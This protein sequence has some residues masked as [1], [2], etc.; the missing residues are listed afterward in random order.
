M[1]PS[2]TPEQ[3]NRILQS[4]VNALQRGDARSAYTSARRVAANDPADTDSLIMLAQSAPE[5]GADAVQDAIHLLA[6]AIGAKPRNEDVLICWGNLKASSGDLA[7]AEQVFRMTVDQFPASPGAAQN[8]AGVLARNGKPAEAVDMFASLI[9]AGGGWPVHLGLVNACMMLGDLDR[10]ETALRTVLQAQP[11]HV[12][13]L[14][15]MGQVHI[16]RGRYDQAAATL[17]KARALQP[18][19]PGVLLNLARLRRRQNRIDEAI[20]LARDCL[21]RK[22]HMVSACVSLCDM[23]EMSNRITELREVLARGLEQFPGHHGLAI[24]AAR[25][26]RRDGNLDQAISRLESLENDP[27]TVANTANTAKTAPEAAANAAESTAGST[28]ENAAARF[29]EL[30]ILYDK[31]DRIAEAFDCFGR[32]K[33]NFSVL[34]RRRGISSAPFFDAVARM[35]EFV[36][37]TDFHALPALSFAD[38]RAAPVFV[39]GFLRSGTTLLH[40]ILDSHEDV[41]VVDEKPMSIAAMDVLEHSSAGFPD[42]IAT[43][44]NRTAG[45]ARRAYFRSLDSWLPPHADG[46]VPVDKF[47]FNLMRLPLLWR[48]FP[49]ATFVFAVR[50]PLDVCL[51]CYMQAFQPSAV[52]SPFL[53]LP[54]T[55]RAYTALMDMWLAFSG[56][57]PVNVVTVRYEDL[58]EDQERITRHLYESVNLSWTDRA[59]MFHEHARQSAPVANPSYHQVVKPVYADAVQRWRRYDEYLRPY[60]EQVAPCVDAFGYDFGP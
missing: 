36:R 33:H 41:A 30:G 40:W 59:L 11:S 49:D 5:V 29:Q 31:K 35:D 21:R 17:E 20:E 54:E 7:G 16:D 55:V 46:P 8:L 18:E 25:L 53:S 22:P 60:Y 32:A 23:L 56:K 19:H 48:L 50:H 28:V 2:L 38:A 44:D 14:N 3:R 4:A 26:D 15:T 43:M 13:A 58:V 57:A 52:T 39:V 51:S 24:Q 45:R 1:A 47:P 12:G 34:S 27:G 42:G 10:A 6:A 9:R 37:R